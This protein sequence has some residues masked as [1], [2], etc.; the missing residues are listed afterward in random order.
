MLLTSNESEESMLEA[1][2]EMKTPE[3]SEN[4]RPAYEKPEVKTLSQRDIVQAVNKGSK[5]PAGGFA[6]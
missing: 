1:K 3:C 2:T 4:S 6:G 5:F